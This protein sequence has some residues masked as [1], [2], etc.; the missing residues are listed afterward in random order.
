[1]DAMALLTRRAKADGEGVWS[2]HPKAGAK[3][4]TMLAH[5]ADD[6]DNKVWFTGESAQDTVKT[7]A[8]GRPGLFGGTCGYYSRAFCCT[9]GHGCGWRPVFPAP[10]PF[11]RAR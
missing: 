9:R 1:M 10:S 11:S 4:A 2:W 5:R 7:I 6:G 3:L 8:Q